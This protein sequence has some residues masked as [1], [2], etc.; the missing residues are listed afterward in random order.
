MLAGAIT[1]AVVTAVVAMVLT[2]LTARHASP[3][4]TTVSRSASPT[5]PEPSPPAPD[6][7]PEPSVPSVATASESPSPPKIATSSARLEDVQT[8]Q[9][10]PTSLTVDA[11][12]VAGSPIDPVGVDPDGK[13]TVPVDI[14]RI[15]WYEYGPAPGDD[16]GSAVLTAHI[17][18]RTQGKGVFYHLDALEAG[19]IVEVDM[20]DGTTRAFV[21]DEIR[22]IPKVDLPTGDIFRRDGDPRLALITCGGEFDPSSRH[23]RDNIVVFATPTG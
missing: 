17:D 12:G 20:S 8:E 21:V 15:G 23:Y 9:I 13:M 10:I 6:P 16:A 22:Q 1:A 4:A 18:S 3:V 5:S 2:L 7:S 14:S 19:A 11:M